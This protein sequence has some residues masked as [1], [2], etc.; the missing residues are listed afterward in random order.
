MRETIPLQTYMAMSIRK[1]NVLDD[2]L[3]LAT[4]PLAL[5]KCCLP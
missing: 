1:G 3:F 4:L 2:T 5:R